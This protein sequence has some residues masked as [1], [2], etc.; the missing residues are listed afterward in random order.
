MDQSGFRVKLQSGVNFFSHATQPFSWKVLIFF[1]MLIYV[2]F[3]GNRVV[4]SAGDDKVYVSQAIEMA[5][6]GSWFTQSMANEPNYYKGPLHYILLR[7]GMVVFGDSM[8]ATVYMNLILVILGAI[9]I[10]A[11]IEKNM[12][13]FDGWPF[14]G[15]LTFAYCAGIYSHTFASQ[16]EVEL[17]AF[18]AIGLY[19]LDRSGP[20]IGD[21]RF[22]IVA[23]IAG[24]LKSPLHAVLLGSSGILF[25]IYQGDFLPRL[26]SPT[27]WGSVLVGILLCASGYL[28]AFLLDRENFWNSYVLRETLWKPANGAPWHYPIIP[29]FTYSVM[30]WTLPAIVTYFDGLTRIWRK[31]RATRATDKTRRLV[32]L[33][34]SLMLPSIAFFLYHPYRGQNYNLPIMG[35][36]ILYVVGIWATRAESWNT[37]Y[38]LSVGFTGLLFLGV[39]TFFTVVTRH[40]DPMPYWWPSWQMSALWVGAI[41]TVRGF[42][43][44]GITFTMARPASLARR[45]VWLLLAMG[46]L[47]TTL[48]E[49]EMIDIRDRIY[50]AKKSN[51]NLKLSYYNL[52]KN[53]WSEWGYLNFMIPYPVSGIFTDQDLKEAIVRQDLILVPGDRWLDDMKI[54]VQNL[55]PGAGYQVEP[56]RRWK[57]KGKGADGKTLWQEAWATKDIRKLE[58]PFF[59][60]HVIPK[61]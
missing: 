23:G 20:G 42:W 32:A 24:W 54:R 7:V 5:H 60:V 46:T 34:A 19:F 3:L 53:I 45:Y 25:W 21:L 35:G 43:R 47:L 37:V 28:P 38:S 48:G 49:R 27:A 17:A 1:V 18:F 44:E 57:T 55:F 33:G 8:W 56:W 22:W 58:R 40:F 50:A 52:E 9:A 29:F 39:M 16:M 31:Q 59:M 14:F 12:P 36:L 6:T 51:E 2:P 30:P 41:L 11:V 10:G 13:E 15:A 61:Q 26:R 4:R